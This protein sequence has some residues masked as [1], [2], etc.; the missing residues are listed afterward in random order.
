MSNTPAGE[1]GST[2]A[3]PTSGWMAWIAARPITFVSSAAY[4]AALISIV[5]GDCAECRTTWRGTLSIV[6]LCLL[7][8]MDRV[9]YPLFGETPS[10]RLALSLLA[11]RL[12]L[13]MAVFALMGPWGN[14]LGLVMLALVPYLAALYLGSKGG[15]SLGVAVWLLGIAPIAV[16]AIPHL[17][18]IITYKAGESYTEYSINWLVLETSITSITMLTILIVFVLVSARI[19]A[20]ERAHT[21]RT[22]RLLRQLEASHARLGMYSESAIVN[23]EE[24]KRTTRDIH[25]ELAH[26]LTAV[27]VQ[28][29]LALAYRDIGP[30]KAEGAI[31]AAKEAISKSL[32]D[33]RRS[34]AILRAKREVVLV[35]ALDDDAGIVIESAPAKGKLWW[36]FPRLFDIIATTIYAGI[37]VLGTMEEGIGISDSLPALAGL[38]LVLALLDR[39]EYAILRVSHTWWISALLGA[40]RLAIM[41]EVFAGVQIWYS[42]FLILLIPYWCA[43]YFG[44]RVGYATT[45]LLVVVISVLLMGIPFEKARLDTLGPA[46]TTYLGTILLLAFVLGIVAATSATVVKESASRA[47]AEKVLADLRK[48]Y[49]DLAE[50]SRQ[51]IE[52]G[53]ARNSLARDIHDGLGH[54]LTAMS[55]QLEKAIAFRSIDPSA[56]DQSLSESKRLVAVA[57]QEIRSTMG[58]L[59]DS[60]PGLSPIGSLEELARHVGHDSLRVQLSIEG[61]EAGYSRRALMTIYRAAQEG[62]TNIQKHASA[63]QVDM[64]LDFGE[65]VA[66]LE[67]KDN[68]KGFVSEQLGTTPEQTGYGL[69]SMSERLELLGGELRIESK[70]GSGT[71]LHITIPKHSTAQASPAQESKQLIMLESSI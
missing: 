47:A 57:L 48:T 39:V 59:R 4:L 42:L 8:I 29:D 53:E 30:E 52:T 35:N 16:A 56:A 60:E 45:G 61:S 7:L 43:I 65:D 58:A 24:L 40:V 31:K 63:Q 66:R 14:A 11:T 5:Q 64:N 21:G 25:D 46:I 2:A 10:K 71:T 17:T 1:G 70:Q 62:L 13:T 38:M 12:A 9:E 26:Y 22:R 19:T 41:Y 44:S 50:Y 15:L 20:L 33:V 51:V 37:F 6:L 27:S 28:I 3:R 23:T 54:Y 36:L 67:I 49:A 55:V 34:V 32:Q 69:Q 68:G 18:R